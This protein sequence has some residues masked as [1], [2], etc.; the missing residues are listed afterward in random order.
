MCI[1]LATY[2]IQFGYGQD[3][4][5]DL[6]RI[7]QT[8]AG[9][10]IVCLQEV[11]RNWRA[12]EH[13]DQP[14]L[15]AYALGLYGAFAPGFEV[16][17]TA[18]G[19]D[20]RADNRPRGFGNM[21]PSRW[22]I[23]YSRAHSLPRAPVNPEDVPAD[24]YP[25]VDLPRTALE[26]VIDVP[27]RPLRVFSTH[28]S[29]LPGAQRGAQISV[30]QDLVTAVSAEAQLWQP[31]PSLSHFVEDM[32]APPVPDDTILCGDFNFEPGHPE[33][34]QMCGHF[35]D[36]WALGGQD[37]E[38]VGTCVE[39]DGR[40]STLDYCFFSTAIAQAVKTAKVEQANKSS[41]HFPV[42]FEL[43]L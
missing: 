20:G 31:D 29:H 32:A 1:K 10:D 36:G 12:C 35:A 24:F 7:T 2:N 39:T 9:Q 23:L 14:A 22:P 42:F 6:G 30:L 25:L 41:D 21:V 37:P 3:M 27:G 38:K 15:I 4:A 17:Q 11:T 18:N 34:A 8:V 33:Y 16:G 28:L 26:T 13:D 43:E 5:Y 40:F 19:P